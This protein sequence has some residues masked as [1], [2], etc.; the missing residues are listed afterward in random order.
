M[1]ME[2]VG[3]GRTSR[4]WQPSEVQSVRSHHGPV[5]LLGDIREYDTRA[6]AD[7]QAL[8]AGKPLGKP[9]TINMLG[10][11]ALS[12]TWA[13]MLQTVPEVMARD[14][15]GN[16]VPYRKA[17]VA[18]DLRQVSTEASRFVSNGL[19][20]SGLDVYDLGMTITPAAYYS[21]YHLSRALGE[22]IAIFMLTASHNENG[23][24]GFKVAFGPSKTA[25]PI[26]QGIVRQVL[27]NGP[28]A[29]GTGTLREYAGIQ[30]AY[31]NALLGNSIL[32]RVGRPLKVVVGTFHGIAGEYLPAM[33]SHLGHKVVP[34]Y[35]E[36]DWSY[37][38]GAPNPENEANLGAISEAVKREGA[39]LG[40]GI[41]AD[42]DRLGVIDN[43]GR[44]IYADKVQMLMFQGLWPALKARGLP[45]Q[46]IID[47]KSTNA[48]ASWPFFQDIGGETVTCATGHW[49]VKAAMKARGLAFGGE[50][51]GHFMVGGPTAPLGEGLFGY[52]DATVSGMLIVRAVSLGS[53]PLAEMYDALPVTHQTPN[54]QPNVPAQHNKYQIIIEMADLFRAMFEKGEKIA[55]KK[56]KEIQ[57]LSSPE[58][59]A[60]AAALSLPSPDAFGVKIVLEDNTTIL[61][62]CSSNKEVLVV[63]GEATASEEAVR[64]ATFHVTRIIQKKYGINVGT[65]DA[66]GAYDQFLPDHQN[67]RVYSLEG[68][69]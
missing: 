25:G 14:V 17:A 49:Y 20:R 37:P 24:L 40:L 67:I 15:S 16:P 22:P 51:S 57:T 4:V 3:V 41:D 58:E 12:R 5:V 30:A 2:L 44:T 59:H 28:F 43:T 21:H 52:D 27:F 19:L 39:D 31:R 56:L 48:W 42:G 54:M 6:V 35:Q 29:K 53:I 66:G 7:S 33:L 26:E 1:K 47:F 11:E 8:T 23:W 55:G 9:E 68:I 34:L 45:P 69:V 61:V 64:E 46:V 36:L 38:Q 13:T 62:R 63:L 65:Q 18:Y 32:N 60:Y 10:V 50:R